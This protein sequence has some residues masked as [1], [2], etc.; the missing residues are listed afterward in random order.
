V[1]N[2]DVVDVVRHPRLGKLLVA[3][4]EHIRNEHGRTKSDQVERLDRW[5]LLLGCLV[6][7]STLNLNL[8]QSTRV[9]ARSTSQAQFEF[10]LAARGKQMEGLANAETRC[11]W[12]R[13]AILAALGGVQRLVLICPQVARQRRRKLDSA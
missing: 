5:R 11:N 12:S 7:R 6:S 1:I 3:R 9:P 8:R 2:L 13:E 4:S 10:F